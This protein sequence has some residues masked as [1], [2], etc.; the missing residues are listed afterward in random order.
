MTPQKKRI[1]VACYQAYVD[2]HCDIALAIRDLMEALVSRG[3]EIR[4]LCGP[5][6]LYGESKTIDSLLHDQGIQ[7]KAYQA[8]HDIEDFSLRMF[9]VGG[10]DCGLWMSQ[11]HNCEP[12]PSFGEAWGTA[13]RQLLSAWHPDVVVTAGEDWMVPILVELAREAGSKSAYFLDCLERPRDGIV[14]KVDATVVRSCSQQEWCRKTFGVEAVLIEPVVSRPQMLCQPNQRRE[15]YLTIVDSQADGKPL[16]IARLLEVLQ[17]RRPD[18]PVLLVTNR[19]DH[20]HALQQT[21]ARIAVDKIIC[22][23]GC[24]EPRDYLNETRILALPSLDGHSSDRNAAIAM[25]NGIPIVG[26]RRGTLPELVGKSGV[27]LELANRI[28][29]ESQDLPE[30]QDVASWIE[31]IELLWDDPHARRTLGEHGVKRSQ[32][33]SIERILDQLTCL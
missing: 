28:T 33:W 9:R 11:E 1:L 3:R 8:S 2:P 32:Q 16:V 20:E 18:I 25:M 19:V 13:Y 12:S 22:V 6:L 4:V 30:L 17:Y 15:T 26:S 14:E 5:R 29:P 27:V 21:G 23:S 31:A 7:A 10:V 24:V